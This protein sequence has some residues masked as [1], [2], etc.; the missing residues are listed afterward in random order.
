MEFKILTALHGE[1]IYEGMKIDYTV[2][3]LLGIK[4]RWQTEICRV[5]NKNILQTG[6]P[7]APIKLGSTR[8]LLKIQTKAYS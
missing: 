4:V 2:K 5:D 3:P 8:I 1:E 6:K 7:K